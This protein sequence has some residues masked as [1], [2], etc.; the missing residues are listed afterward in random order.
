MTSIRQT[1]F[2][3][4]ALAFTCLCC[5]AADAQAALLLEEPYGFFGTLNPTGHTA[6]YFE[7][8]CADTPVHLRRCEPGE[9]GAVIARYEGIDGYD[10]V[11]VP[12]VPYLYSVEDAAEVPTHVDHDTV[13]RLR[14]HYRETHLQDLGPKLQPGSLVRGGWTQL[15]G[16]AY[17]RR[18]YA[19]RFQ[20]TTAQ[21]DALIAKLNSGINQSDFN[22][23]FSN[24]ADFA[25][26]VLNSYFPH[27][28]RRSIFPD[29]G[30]T[31]PK[32]ITYKLTRYARKH[33]ETQLTVFEIPQVPGYRRHSGSN[34]N[35]DE[36]FVTTLYA[37]PIAL[38]NPYLAGGLF[39]DYIVR[40]HYHLIPKSPEILGPN[41]LAPLTA[42]AARNDNSAIAGNPASSV[43]FGGGGP[44]DMSSSAGLSTDAQAGGF[45]S[46]GDGS[47]AMIDGTNSDMRG[48]ASPHE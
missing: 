48:I 1:L 16:A 25:R 39:V 43:G 24:C 46:G 20:T 35:I 37:V 17:E 38:L 12:L 44:M 45:A 2:C 9:L 31:T 33:P 42:Q 3:S 7:H 14:N 47:S 5:S 30:M 36:S 11:A 8:I 13:L 32:Q 18:I 23:L 29:A 27:T 10:W 26:V 40:G 15:I 21:D 6:V 41:D 28:F 19:F 34:K 4:V 22:L